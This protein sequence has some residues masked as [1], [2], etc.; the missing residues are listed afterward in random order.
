M[1]TSITFPDLRINNAEQ[2]IESASEPSPNT[3]LYLTMGKVEPWANVLSPNVANASGATVFE[4]W[5]NMVGGKLLNGGDFHHIVP[6]H[7]WTANNKYI[8]YDHMD[9]NLLDGNTEFYIVTSEYNV[10][11]C[12]ANNNGANSTVEPTAVSPY[13]TTT[14]SDNYIWKY[15]YTVA[16]SEQLRFMTDAYIPVKTLT[17]DDGSS[18]WQVQENATEGSINSIFI[19]NEGVNYTNISNIIVTISG[20]GSSANATANVDISSNTI[21]YILVVNPGTDYTY[22]SVSITGGG[23][24]GA[25]GRAIISPQGGHG[26]NPLYELGGNDIIL[27]GKLKFDENSTL[28]VTNDFGQISILKDPHLFDTANVATLSAF[29]QCSSLTCLGSGNYNQDEF[30]YQGA[31]F[32]AATFT[33]RVVS[34]S[35]ATGLLLLINTTGTPTAA[36]LLIG[37]ESLTIRTISSISSGDL[38]K[39]SGRIL[40]V[41]NIQSITRSSDQTEDFRIVIHF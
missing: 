37:E 30:V 9:P 35:S 15:M 3:R 34:W 18:Q 20:D 32:S 4:V 12:L 38:E 10:Y 11:K 22:A 17:N 25:E 1:S 33:G 36:Q 19:T 40:Y 27:N 16:D 13:T 41:D 2:F 26:S 6:R 14:T 8:A 29:L 39:Y 31:S 7:N 28:P 23:G 24:S 5:N 21:D